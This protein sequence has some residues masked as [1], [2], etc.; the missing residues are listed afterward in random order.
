[1][2]QSDNSAG[3]PARGATS[4]EGVGYDDGFNLRELFAK[5]SRGF[6]Q[7]AGLALLGLSIGAVVY[8]T[9][10]MFLPVTTSTRVV[11]SFPGVEKGLYPDGSRFEPE[12]VFTPSIVADAIARQGLDRSSDFSTAVRA[13]LSIEGVIPDAVVK[14]RDRLRAAGQPVETFVPEEYILRL[15]LPRRTLIASKQRNLLLNAIVSTFRDNFQR[16][17]SHPPPPSDELS[18]RSRMPI[19]SSMKGSSSPRFTA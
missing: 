17:Y 16:N 5:L 13:S 15:T 6:N 14:E 4:T 1:M 11:F 10:A 19:T 8:L 2:T 9:L 3:E 12:D 18:R 7:I